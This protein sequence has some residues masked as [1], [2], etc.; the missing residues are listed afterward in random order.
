MIIAIF[1][2][3]VVLGVL[4]AVPLAMILVMS[5]SRAKKQAQEML[6]SGTIDK[7][8]ARKIL[9]TLSACRDNEGKR[10]YN[11]LADAV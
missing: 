7:A 5:Q 6:D 11:K 1:I 9:R 8:K 3:L 2:G 10:L 4:L